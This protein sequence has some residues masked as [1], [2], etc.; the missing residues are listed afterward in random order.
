MISYLVTTPFW[1]RMA[2]PK[3]L[4]W[5]IDTDQTPTVY[6]T[7]DDGPHPTATPF[8]LELL[9]KY[10]AHATFFCVGHNVTKFLG[11]YQRILAEGHKTANHTFNH[12][13]GRKTDD[14]TYLANIENAARHIDSNLFRPPYGMIRGTQAKQ[15]RQLHP[16]WKI[17]MWSVLSGDFD[18]YLPA[19]KCLQNVLRNIKPGAI[20]L[21]HDSEK[22]WDRMSFALPRVLEHCRQQGWKMNAIP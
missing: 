2:F 11:V 8:V 10:N 22:A 19:E 12:M 3:G 6:I 20:I 4:V 15:L 14:A 7:F 9:K 13:N 17:I 1:L 16:D 5:S 18:R 21:F